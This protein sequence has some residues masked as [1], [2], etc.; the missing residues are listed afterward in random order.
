MRIAEINKCAR[1]KPAG[2]ELTRVIAID[3]K[4]LTI[5]KLQR[6]QKE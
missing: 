3:V 5:S 4:N 6:R 1:V 2:G